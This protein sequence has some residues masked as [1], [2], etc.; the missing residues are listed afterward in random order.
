MM[1]IMAIIKGSQLMGDHASSQKPPSGIAIMQII[2]IVNCDAINL[3]LGIINLVFLNDE[4]VK[5]FFRG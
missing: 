4:D 1:G 5:D 3:T 2:N